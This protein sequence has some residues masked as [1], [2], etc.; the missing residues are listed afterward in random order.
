M[1]P[2]ALILA[3]VLLAAGGGHSPDSTAQ[4]AA[5]SPS[6]STMASPSPEPSPTPPADPNTKPL[7]QTFIRT[8]TGQEAGYVGEVTAFAWKQPTAAGAP[9]PASGGEWGSAEVQ[10]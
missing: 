2:H 1:R 6:P 4:P 3:A 7:G 5:A 9:K 10:L 8:G